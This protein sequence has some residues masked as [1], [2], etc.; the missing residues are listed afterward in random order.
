MKAT[1][2]VAFG[3]FVLFVLACASAPA[4]VVL[5]ETGPEQFAGLAKTGENTVR[6]QA[7]LRTNG[8]GVVTAAGEKVFLIPDVPLNR[9]FVTN[10]RN[11]QGRFANYPSFA[12][13]FNRE[14]TAD[15]EG[16]FLFL[17]VPNG[18]FIVFTE[19]RWNA[20]E[21]RKAAGGSYYLGD[22]PQGGYLSRSVTV[23]SGESERLIVSE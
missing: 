5:V 16:G 10:C 11:G 8:G 9:E 14:T 2:A 13:D 6:G 7:F 12:R 19:I 3:L 18:D 22:N 20:P 1:L 15:S 4:P 17:D 23:P 21:V